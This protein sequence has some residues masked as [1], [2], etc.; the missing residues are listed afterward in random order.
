MAT[1]KLNTC[2][3]KHLKTF[4][5]AVHFYKHWESID[6]SLHVNLVVDLS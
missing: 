6:N 2:M 5:L 1:R 4:C 3:N